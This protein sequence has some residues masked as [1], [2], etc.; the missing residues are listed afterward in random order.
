MSIGAVLLIV[1]GL[2]TVIQP[3]LGV[4]LLALALPL[5]P[6]P[7]RLDP[8]LPTLRHADAPVLFALLDRV[9]DAAGVRRFDAIQLSPEFSVTVTHYGV[10]RKR[11]LVLGLPLW[12]AQPGRQPLAAVAHAMGHLGGHD[13]RNDA[14]VGTALKSLTAGSWTLRARSDTYITAN[15]SA[16]NPHADAVITG[17]RCFNARTRR[18]QW[19][20]WISRV[21]TAATARL[22]LRL[23]RPVTRHAVFE[24]D[25]VAARTASTEAAIAALRDRHLA[26]AVTRE[27][28]RLAIKARSLTGKRSV[29]AAQE[30]LWDEVARFVETLREQRGSGQTS[31]PENS[32]A[33]GGTADI[34]SDTLR[35]ARLSRAPIH[36]A[37]ITLEEPDRNRIEEELRLPKQAVARKVIQDCVPLAR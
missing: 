3:L 12:A 25:D 32:G 31:E 16:H 7:G 23:T 13:L 27:V 36:H 22:L 14:F 1:L 8:D 24:A 33:V 17:A 19:V 35:V 4:A 28:H 26:D 9:A 11:C 30:E 37:T 10:R 15:A 34:P 29:T 2:R 5:R 18:G 6:R 21:T 20:L